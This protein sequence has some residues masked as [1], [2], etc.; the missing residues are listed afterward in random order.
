MKLSE[1]AD[2]LMPAAAVPG[3]WLANNQPHRRPAF[4]DV[5]DALGMIETRGYVAMIE[6]TDAMV[7]AADVRV[8]GWQAAGGGLVTTLVRGDVAA[9]RAASEAGAEAAAAVGEVVA[10]HIIPRPHP[11]LESLLPADPLGLD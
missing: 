8:L 3:K 7:K 5:N 2:Q 10:V 4:D 9:V 1:R 6:A 11:S